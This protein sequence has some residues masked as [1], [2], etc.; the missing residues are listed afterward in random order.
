MKVQDKRLAGAVLC[1]S[2]LTKGE[3]Y[4]HITSGNVILS[5]GGEA[6]VYLRSQYPGTALAPCNDRVWRHIQVE[7]HIVG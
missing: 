6:A 4:E 3:V 2:E 7:L 1:G 5:G